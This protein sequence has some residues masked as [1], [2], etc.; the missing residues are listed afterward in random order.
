MQQRVNILIYTYMKLGIHFSSKKLF[1][2]FKVFLDDIKMIFHF[3]VD[4]GFW[5]KNVRECSHR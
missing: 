1:F 4:L 3:S 5:M 2:F